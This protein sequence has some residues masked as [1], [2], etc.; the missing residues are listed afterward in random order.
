MINNEV[1]QKKWSSSAASVLT[2]VALGAVGGGGGVAKTS[3]LKM[4]SQMAR[5]VGWTR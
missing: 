4:T 1:E 3:M 2:P 5:T